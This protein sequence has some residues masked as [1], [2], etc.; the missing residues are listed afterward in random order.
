MAGVTVTGLGT[1]SPEMGA[2]VALSNTSVKPGYQGKGYL[3]WFSER[4]NVLADSL[5]LCKFHSSWRFGIGFERLATLLTPLTGI[6]WTW[7]DLFKVAEN[8]INAERALL[9]LYN[10]K[11]YLPELFFEE[12][13]E[14]HVHHTPH[15]MVEWP[16]ICP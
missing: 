2:S 11:D 9:E 14:S 12:S 16:T 4:M 15:T 5:G 10:Q 7:K 1:L 3:T 13:T 8:G 6:Q